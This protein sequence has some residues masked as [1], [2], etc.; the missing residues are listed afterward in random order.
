MEVRV[1]GEDGWLT[2]DVR[3]GHRPARSWRTCEAS[4]RSR[5]WSLWPS[6]TSA[7]RCIGSTCARSRPPS[8]MWPPCRDGSAKT[9]TASSGPSRS[10]RTVHAVR[11][12]MPSVRA[13]SQPYIGSECIIYT[14]NS[15]DVCL[16]L[17]VH[18]YVRSMHAC[19]RICK[20]T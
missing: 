7:A 9:S 15:G 1:F 19:M 10:R 8:R 6:G 12:S 17:P 11:P 4:T 3:C 18:M 14:S 16:C 5:P 2:L 20:C 13:L